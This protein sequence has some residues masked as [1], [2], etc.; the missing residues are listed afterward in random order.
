MKNP[1]FIIRIFTVMR[2]RVIAGEPWQA[3]LADYGFSSE[4]YAS[5]Q[6]DGKLRFTVKA[7]ALVHASK[8][9][10]RRGVDTD[11]F[12]AYRCPTCKWWHLTKDAR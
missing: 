8:Y 6:C 10:R 2:E 11:Q 12:R 3:V 5:R 9:L 7:T 1:P 4:S